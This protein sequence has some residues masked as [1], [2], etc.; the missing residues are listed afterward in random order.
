[1]SDSLCGG[2]NPNPDIGIDAGARKYIDDQV[3]KYARKGVPPE[4]I[5]YIF[6]LIFKYDTLLMQG[7]KAEALALKRNYFQEPEIKQIFSRFRSRI[8]R[9]NTSKRKPTTAQKRQIIDRNM[10]HLS[11]TAWWGSDAIDPETN[12]SARNYRYLSPSH[13]RIHDPNKMSWME[14]IPYNLW[15]RRRKQI[16]DLLNPFDAHGDPRKAF[17]NA[18]RDTINDNLQFYSQF[19]RENLFRH[20]LPHIRNLRRGVGQAE[21]V[22]Q[23]AVPAAPA[24]PAAAAAVDA[25]DQ[26]YQE[27]QD[28]EDAMYAQ[29]LDEYENEHNNPQA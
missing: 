15:Y 4:V 17:L 10:R 7:R 24:A 23:M 3:L 5:R 14:S 11:R 18:F 13:R 8:H 19:P 12:E 27:E 2:W 6:F 26:Q 9:G 16:A 1:M 21:P 22:A 29:M 20:Y 28:A 25:A